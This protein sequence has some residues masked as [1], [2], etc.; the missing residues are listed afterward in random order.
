MTTAPGEPDGAESID[1][2]FKTR[3]VSAEEAA[4]VTA[5]L[6][7]AVH[8]ER[9][10]PPPAARSEWSHPRAAVRPPVEVGPR[11]WAYSAR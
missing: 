7:A 2:K 11:R 4:A 9:A 1:L 6:V 8:E 3:N 5:V 10:V